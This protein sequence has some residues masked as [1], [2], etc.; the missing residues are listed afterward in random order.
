[1]DWQK[2]NSVST[3]A[4]LSAGGD[5]SG[6][7]DPSDTHL[8]PCSALES[9]RKRA[10]WWIHGALIRLA[11]AKHTHETL[12]G[13]LFSV[14]AYSW[15]N[16]SLC[17]CLA[18]CLLPT[19]LTSIPLYGMFGSDAAFVLLVLMCLAEELLSTKWSI[20]TSDI[21]SENLRINTH[22]NRTPKNP[23]KSKS[24]CS[25]HIKQS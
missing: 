14:A 15:G 1:M 2:V 4:F 11:R 23:H 21:K 12:S 24:P 22:I 5:R 17:E 19:L 16:P 3:C 7:D 25:G 18:V 13:M 6:M 20:D 9:W 8:Q 10:S